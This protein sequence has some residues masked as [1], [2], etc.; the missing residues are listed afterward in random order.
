MKQTRAERSFMIVA[1]LVSALTM[2]VCC[3]LFAE[4]LRLKWENRQFIKAQE[5]A[6]L[7]TGIER[8]CSKAWPLHGANY[9]ACLRDWE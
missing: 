7:L 6:Q 4:F 8:E 3:Y 2:I 1:W 5:R 9:Q